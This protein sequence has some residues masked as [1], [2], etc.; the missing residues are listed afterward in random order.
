MYRGR[1]DGAV[2]GLDELSRYYLR[3][4]SAAYNCSQGEMMRRLIQEKWQS[5]ADGLEL[6]DRAAKRI[7]A[8]S[9]RFFGDRAGETQ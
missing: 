6:S 5:E 8:I 4:L 1:T 9:K 3:C 7:R 2:Y